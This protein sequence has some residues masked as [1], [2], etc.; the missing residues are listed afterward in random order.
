[1]VRGSDGRTRTELSSGMSRT[2]LASVSIS[3]LV[4]S[5]MNV[6]FMSG[7]RSVVGLSSGMSRT[8]LASVSISSLVASLM[9]VT[10]MSGD[11]SVVGLSSGMSPTPLA[12]VS[13]LSLVASLMN[14]T[15]MS[16]DRSVVGLSS[17]MSRTPLA[18]VS[19]SSLV[20]SLI[21]VIFM[22]GD[23]VRC[24]SFAETKNALNRSRVDAQ[25]VHQFLCECRIIS[26]SVGWVVWCAGDNDGTFHIVCIVFLG[27]AFFDVFP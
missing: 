25:F 19:I 3:S 27:V 4:A 16:G 14:V 10:F 21:N 11:R 7:D 22:S 18:S 2:P 26:P 17:G 8:P 9:N 12:S 5:L 1:M 15:F 13:I 23:R 24:R 6:T 20:T